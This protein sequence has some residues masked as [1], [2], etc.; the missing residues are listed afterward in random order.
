MQD[1]KELDRVQLGGGLITVTCF[2]EN[3]KQ[4]ATVMFYSGY[5]CF[6]I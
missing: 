1:R 4:A 3:K 6:K 5:R 2:N